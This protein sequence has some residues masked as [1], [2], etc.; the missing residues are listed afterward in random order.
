[1]VMKVAVL[2]NCIFSSLR[3]RSPSL[4]CPWELGR[5]SLPKNPSVF[6]SAHFINMQRHVIK[7][8]LSGV[9]RK[10]A[11]RSAND[12]CIIC[13]CNLKIEFESARVSFESIF[14]PSKRKESRGLVEKLPRT[15]ERVCRPCGRA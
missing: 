2:S 10:P 14:K 12:F 11:L 9:P 3:G 15:S 6:L 13:Q 5:E 1:M 4:G 7:M 8:S